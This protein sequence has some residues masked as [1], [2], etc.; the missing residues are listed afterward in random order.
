MPLEVDESPSAVELFD[1]LAARFSW[2]GP[3]R[4]ASRRPPRPG[5]PTF[6]A[7]PVLAPIEA[8]YR[9][10]G[11]TF[12]TSAS[13]M[14]FAARADGALSLRDPSSAVTAEVR[15]L[16]ASPTNGAIAR[17]HVV[18]PNAAPGGGDLVVT[19]IPGGAEDW[20]TLPSAGA[21]T[22]LE[23]AVTLG[24]AVAGLR[25]VGG[26]LELLDARGAPRLRMVRPHV[27]SGDGRVVLGE[28]RVDGCSFDSSSAPPFG[29]PVVAPGASSC[30]VR[31]TWN[32]A[33]LT[34]PA[35]VDPAWTTTMRLAAPRCG[36][37]ATRLAN[38]SVL[39]A[40]GQTTHPVTTIVEVATAEVWSD[41]VWTTTGPLATSRDLAAAATLANGEILVSGGLTNQGMDVLASAE[42][43]S[44]QTGTWRPTGPLAVPRAGHTATAIGDGTVLV[45]AGYD[46]SG[47]HFTE[48]ERFRAGVFRAAGRIRQT[49][50]FHT[51]VALGGGRVL[52]GGG[53]DPASGAIGSLELYTVGAGWSAAASLAPMRTPR[54]LHA[55]AVLPNGD[56]L[57]VGGYNA[58]SGALATTERYSPGTNTWTNDATMER[59]RYDS[60]PAT[61]PDGRVLFVSGQ[62]LTW[63]YSDGELYDP[64]T[65]TFARTRGASAPRGMAHTATPLFDGRALAVGGL[66]Q[67]PTIVA[68]AD[69]FDVTQPDVDAGPDDEPDG[70]LSVDA[71]PPRDAATPPPQSGDAG[72][73]DA[74]RPGQ[75]SA[76]APVASVAPDRGVPDAEVEGPLPVLSGGCGIGGKTQGG[77]GAGVGFVVLAVAA[78]A[79][80]RRRASE[81]RERR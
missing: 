20:V 60:A 64:S 40:G 9:R 56:V 66:N 18:Y 17:G 37:I 70:S 71:S 63:Q 48:A 67:G 74:S 26:T 68:A 55:S 10:S 73:T 29:R 36:H 69:L 24:S 80:A 47:D 34:Y 4:S 5:V 27:V 13:P 19:P 72:L 79:G 8:A 14:A 54:T 21:A 45:S 78:W 2:P 33:A 46:N 42:I 49:R 23:Y 38:G 28:V 76:V 51:A 30:G 61:M 59:A 44:P 62:S 31:V 43:Y 39:V 7:E 52:V 22:S 6:H 77:A 35:L 58:A 57:F 3:P 12:E 50:F 81:R 53:T 15:L 16:G 11:E 41:G 65:R 1:S 75:D 32:P 25:L